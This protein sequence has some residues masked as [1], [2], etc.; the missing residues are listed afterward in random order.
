MKQKYVFEKFGSCISLCVIVSR[1]LKW[2]HIQ[3]LGINMLPNVKWSTSFWY[4]YFQF[5]GNHLRRQVG[6]VKNHSRIG[7]QIKTGTIK[8]QRNKTFECG[9]KGGEAIKS[10]E[11][12][13][14]SYSSTGNRL[15][16]LTLKP[17]RDRKIRSTVLWMMP[18][19]SSVDLGKSDSRIRHTV[20]MSAE[21]CPEASPKI[22]RFTGW[23]K[24]FFLFITRKKRSV[25][26]QP[27]ITL[28]GVSWFDLAEKND[29]SKK[30]P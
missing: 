28:G 11:A 22:W 24:Y 17:D 23:K 10:V 12:E 2:W 15:K 29:L 19:S 25:A 27:C 14:T 4:I 18:S 5:V 9:F 13:T 6:E 8:H 26:F 21:V 30:V 7:T 3:H 20:R 1:E 16:N